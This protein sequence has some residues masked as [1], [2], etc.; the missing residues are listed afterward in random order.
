M[1]YPHPHDR[2]LLVT[3]EQAAEWL[4]T[5]NQA[6]DSEKV[7]WYARLILEGRWEPNKHRIS[8]IRL[9]D[10]TLEHGNHRLRAILHA[11]MAAHMWVR[12]A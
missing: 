10:G 3:P 6:C 11:G 1:S 2:R 9:V 12:G 5:S 4:S 7:D 8:P